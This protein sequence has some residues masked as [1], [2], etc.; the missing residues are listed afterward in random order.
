MEK[1]G[2][3]EFVCTATALS[4]RRRGLVQKLAIRHGG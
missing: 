3:T 4:V 2:L 1:T